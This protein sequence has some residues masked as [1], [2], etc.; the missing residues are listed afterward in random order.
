MDETYRM[1]GAEHQADL[2]REAANW[3]RAAPVRKARARRRVRI[4]LH[5]DHIAHEEAQRA[6][7]WYR[8]IFTA[9]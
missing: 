6:L 1:L 8:R 3:H 5:R 2:A 7:P 4:A 9:V